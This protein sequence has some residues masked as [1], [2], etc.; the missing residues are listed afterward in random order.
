MKGKK[1]KSGYVSVV[2]LP[3]VGKSTLINR[4]LDTKI[5]AVS[6]KPQTTRNNILGIFTTKDFQ[7]LFTDTP[8]YHY[9]EKDINKPGTFKNRSHTNSRNKNYAQPDQGK[10][11]FYP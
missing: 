1:F 9:S 5:M 6:D 7:I 4:I 10:V 3:N 8:G 11:L 2:G